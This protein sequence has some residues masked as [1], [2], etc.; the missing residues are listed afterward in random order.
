MDI[1]SYLRRIGQRAPHATTLE[2]LNAILF[3]HVRTIPFENISVLLG[4]PISL[5]LEDV[6]NK[7][8]HGC[9]GGYCFEHNT[10]LLHVLSDLGFT[11]TTLSAR[12]RYQTPDRYSLPRTHMCLRVELEGKSYLV[13]GGFGALSPT[14][15]LQ[16]RPDEEQQTPHEPR[17]LRLEGHWEGLTLRSPDAAIVHEAYLGGTWHPIYEFALDPMPLADREMGNWYTSRHANSHFR[18]KLM[19]ARS[20]LDGRVTLL[21]REL[22]FRKRD[23]STESHPVTT[24]NELTDVLAKEFGIALPPGSRLSCAGLGDLT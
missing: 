1:D 23:G 17:R 11:V 10:L 13:D 22:T 2:A 21:N 7:L 9:R 12:S 20:S 4:E 6:V 8:V 3:A 16:L 18:T 24:H 19:V 15:A 14:C 5:E